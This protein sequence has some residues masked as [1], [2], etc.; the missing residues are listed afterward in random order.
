MA[1][2]ANQKKWV[3]DGGKEAEEPRM[4]QNYHKS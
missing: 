2:A 3:K 1:Q 4:M